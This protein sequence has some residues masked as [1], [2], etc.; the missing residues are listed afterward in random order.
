MAT[1][2]THLQNVAASV[3]ILQPDSFVSNSEQTASRLLQCAR[4]AGRHLVSRDWRVLTFEHTLTTVSG[5]LEYALPTLPAFH[6]F[7]PGTAYDRSLWRGIVG[8]QTA[9]QWQLGQAMLVSPGTLLRTFRIK[10]DGT[11][12]PR[13][14]KLYLLDDPGDGVELAFEYVTKEWVYDGSGAYR[15]DIA[16]DTDQPVFD[17]QLFEL[18]CT[19]RILRANGEPFFDE[20][21]EANR[22]ADRLYAQEGGQ[23]IDMQPRRWTMTPNIPEAS[24]PDA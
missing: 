4:A 2:K 11:N 3:G 5:T 18:E 19:W 10:T 15:E 21:D 1:I 6:H 8:P 13:V 16:A 23:T 12:A 14:D 7:K 20:K 17:P 22:L 24:W 9:A